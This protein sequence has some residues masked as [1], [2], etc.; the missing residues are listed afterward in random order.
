MDDVWSRH[1]AMGCR[2]VERPPST[3]VVPAK[4]VLMGSDVAC[5]LIASARSAREAYANLQPAMM[6]Y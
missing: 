1:A 4:A 5:R 2:M 6:V 3:V